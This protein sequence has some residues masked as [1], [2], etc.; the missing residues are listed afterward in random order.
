MVKDIQN[1][2]FYP[3]LSVWISG[4]ECLRCCDTDLQFARW[5]WDRGFL[6][7]ASSPL[8]DSRSSHIHFRSRGCARPVRRRW[9][10]TLGSPC[11]RTAAE[12]KHSRCCACVCVFPKG[13]SE[14]TVHVRESDG[15]LMCSVPL[16][17]LEPVPFFLSLAESAPMPALC[18][19]FL[20]QVLDV[21]LLRN[22][23][24]VTVTKIQYQ[25]KNHIF[26]KYFLCSV[27]LHIVRY[28]FLMQFR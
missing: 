20:K 9:D 24:V 3:F 5:C 15:R 25:M 28:S 13:S 1:L 4:G 14:K 18:W 2:P 16:T 23:L 11:S 6:T 7:A 17:Q 27:C 12:R 26:K 8:S 21:L 22:L 10:E 19:R